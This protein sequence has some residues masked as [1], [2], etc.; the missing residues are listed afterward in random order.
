MDYALSGWAIASERIHMARVLQ[1]TLRSSALL[2][3]VLFGTVASNAAVID[4]P[5]VTINSGSY[6]AFQ[7]TTTGLTWLD[8]NNVF[9]TN[10][11][12]N[13]VNTLLAGSGFHLATLSEL[14]ALQ[15]SIPA[16]PANFAG[17]AP[18]IG[19][20]YAGSPFAT[21]SRDLAWGIYEDGNALDGIS[22]SWKYAGD[23]SW[24]FT[25][26]AVGQSN[27]L[28]SVNSTDQDLGAWIVGNGSSA[29]PE[30]G[31]FGL[32]GLSLVGAAAF[33]FRSRKA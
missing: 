9:F 26:N 33:R 14:Q 24:N 16:V 32:L 6:R 7:D 3:T 4:V 5:N 28:M 29:V 10:H 23:L 22:Y 30:P 12:Y 27:A 19:A 31:T 18:I 1:T 8:L 21:G 11:T 17:E 13:T 2:V 20:N 15:A 25:G